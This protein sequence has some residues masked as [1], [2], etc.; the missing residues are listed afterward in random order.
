MILPVFA[1]LD[2]TTIEP[3]MQPRRVRSP[4]TRVL[5]PGDPYAIVRAS[6]SAHRHATRTTHARHATPRTS[7]H[8]LSH[9]IPKYHRSPVEPSGS[10]QLTVSAMLPHDGYDPVR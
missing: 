4:Y 1:S 10:V 3:R 8:S 9:S 7:P 2:S 5:T 6:P